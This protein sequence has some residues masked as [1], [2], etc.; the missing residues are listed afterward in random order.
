M[1]EIINDEQLLAECHSCC[2]D[3]TEKPQK[4]EYT[5]A[6]LEV[7]SWK[8]GRFPQI[9]AFIDSRAQAHPNLHIQYLRG[10]DPVLKMK[11]SAGEET[12][13]LASWTTDNLDEYLKQKLIK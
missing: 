3:D 13:N 4:V 7:C 1:K 11:S 9:K 2:E 12:I 10:A 5:S 8:I 6:S